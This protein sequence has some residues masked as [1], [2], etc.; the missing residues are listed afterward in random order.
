MA[1]KLSMTVDFICMAYIYMLMLV[2]MTL[3]LIQGQSGL[4]EETILNLGNGIQTVHGG[5]L[6]HDI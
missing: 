3:T 2:L 4:T 6:M 5:R 1:F